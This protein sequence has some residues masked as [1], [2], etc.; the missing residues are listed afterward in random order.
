M[1]EDQTIDDLEDILLIS[2]IGFTSVVM[3]TGDLAMSED[4]RHRCKM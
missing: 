3:L 2:K 4:I 1:K